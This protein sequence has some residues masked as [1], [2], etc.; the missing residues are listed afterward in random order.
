MA[1]GQLEYADEG[2]NRIAELY[3]LCRYSPFGCNES[4]LAKLINDF[5]PQQASL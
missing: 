5:H 3:I 1:S 4:E 2:I